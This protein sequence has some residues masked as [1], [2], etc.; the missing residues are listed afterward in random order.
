MVLLYCLGFDDKMIFLYILFILILIPFTLT[1]YYGVKFFNA[2]KLYFVFGKKGSGK[3]TTLTKLSCDYNKRGFKVYCTDDSIAG[4]YT[5]DPSNFGKYQ[6]E[7][8]SVVLIDEVSL[9]WSNRD[10][11]KFQKSVEQQFRY[12]R[13]DKLIIYLFSQTF[14]IDKKIRDLCD[15]MYL[16]EKRFNCIVWLKKISKNPTITEADSRGE[17]R[18]TEN[19]EFE[20]L[21][22]WPFGSRKMVWIPKYVK[23]FD[24]FNIFGW[25]R[26]PMPATFTQPL[27]APARF[28]F[29]Q[30][31]FN[32]KFAQLK[33]SKVLQ[34]AKRKPPEYTD[35]IE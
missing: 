4:T 17:S 1:F 22:F 23:L 34:A 18:V 27:P 5:F 26:D 19:L 15:G 29:R 16:A 8:N 13:K 3:T 9:I 6:F 32:C 12:Q 11:A 31:R 30:L 2:F 10:F 14:D 28:Q 33:L 24:S 20:P 35:E 25:E 21:I 7:E